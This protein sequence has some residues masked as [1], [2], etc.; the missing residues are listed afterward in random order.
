MQLHHCTSPE[1]EKYM[2]R[3][4]LI[5]VPVGSTEQH[6]PNGLIGT[7][8]I[9]PEVV[10]NGVAKN[11]RVLVAPT[12]SIGMS[13]HHM[14]FK[15]SITLRPSTLM[16]VVTDVIDSLAK[17]GFEHIYFLNGHG[18][19]IAT[20]NAAFS[21]Y[22]A[23]SSLSGPNSKTSVPYTYIRNWWQGPRVQEYSSKNFV[24]IEGSHATPTEVSLT[25][26]ALPECV[27][28]VEITP[29]IAPK[30]NFLDAEDYR[31]RFPDGR[32]GSNP[33]VASV[34]HGEKIFHASVFDT[35]EHLHEL[36]VL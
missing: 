4:R 14:G 7:D 5:L 3:S 24:G 30:G 26:F 33:A 12:I 36:D 34:E 29:P 28:A 32:M 35:V 23:K 31:S 11:T 13:Q 16:R 6:G 21:E 10:A 8:A 19:N 25:Y 20:I 9:C 18:G 2:T 15:G 22:Y 1:V 17:H 27:K